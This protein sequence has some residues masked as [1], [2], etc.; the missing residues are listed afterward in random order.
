MHANARLAECY[1]DK[2]DYHSPADMLPTNKQ[3]CDNLHVTLCCVA[4]SEPLTILNYA[5]RVRGLHYRHWRH[6]SVRRCMTVFPASLHYCRQVLSSQLS[7]RQIIFMVRLC[8]TEN[9][10]EVTRHFEFWRGLTQLICLGYTTNPSKQCCYHF[11]HEASNLMIAKRTIQG[12]CRVKILIVL[13]WSSSQ[14]CRL[15]Y[16]QGRL[17]IFLL[18]NITITNWLRLQT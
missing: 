15:L 2:P 18:G 4:D 7:L 17:S 13:F 10:R 12:I 5:H 14:Y 11:S 8:T 3:K 1:S 9:V 16:M 6:R